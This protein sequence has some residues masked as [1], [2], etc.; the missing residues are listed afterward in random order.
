MNQ[1]AKI[2]EAD[3]RVGSVI[4]PMNIESLFRLALEKDAS[5]ETIEKMMGI[6]RE[7]NAEKAKQFFDE[8]L[9]DFQN[10]CPPVSKTKGVPDRSGAMAYHYAPFEEIVAAV[11]PYLKKY[12]FSYALDTDVESQA[13]WVIAVCKVKHQAGHTEVSKAKFPM[14]TKTQIMSDT[15]VYA[16]ALT[17]ASRRVF[18]NAFGIVTA[19]EDLN[20]RTGTV[21]P[22]GP[23]AMA[24]DS[25]KD[26]IKGLAKQLWDLMTTVRG[27]EKNWNAANQ[28]LWREEI[29]D[30]ASDETA[31]NLSKERFIVVL[32]KAREL[33]K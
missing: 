10:D 31:P 16:A 24:P 17:F 23:S 25:G 13:G 6:R 1:L 7:L 30:A 9:R 21:K 18:C 8:S 12:G 32:A 27:A 5:A 15:Q 14:G 20:G 22:Q 19:G 33:L 11:R 4:E 3:M 26:E 29:L 2:P 28:W